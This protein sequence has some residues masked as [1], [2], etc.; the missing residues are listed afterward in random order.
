M[1]KG[2][3]RSISKETDM[4][5]SVKKKEQN[6]MFIY[7]KKCGKLSFMVTVKRWGARFG[8]QP[9]TCVCQNIVQ[10]GEG[11]FVF[12]LCLATSARKSEP[13]RMTAKL[14]NSSAHT[15]DFASKAYKALHTVAVL[16]HCN[17]VSIGYTN[18]WF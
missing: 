6:S 11:I 13:C 17:T 14:R 12:A 7:K 2:Q 5:T 15:D 18:S 4:L 3:S 1:R 10:S 8:R 9:H 16:M